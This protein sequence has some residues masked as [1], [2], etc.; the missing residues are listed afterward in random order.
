MYER[1]FAAADDELFVACF[2]YCDN[3]ALVATLVAPVN[4]NQVVA[5]A[6][7]NADFNSCVVANDQGSCAEAMWCDRC[8]CEHAGVGGDDWTAYAQ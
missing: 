6:A 7:V 8:Q 1:V 5:T 4:G 3:G 2:L